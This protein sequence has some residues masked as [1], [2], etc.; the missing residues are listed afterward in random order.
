MGMIIYAFMWFIFGAVAQTYI[1]A[2]DS[3]FTFGQPWDQ[4][5]EMIEQIIYYHPIISM[6]GWL[7]WGFL[8]SARRDVRSWVD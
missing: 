1:D 5:L 6:I 4:V 8:N 2:I 3:A 7:I